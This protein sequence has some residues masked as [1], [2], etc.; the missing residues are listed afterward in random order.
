[1][2]DLLPKRWRR[3]VVAAVFSGMTLLV[4]G[5]ATAQGIGSHVGGG[6]LAGDAAGLDDGYV[7]FGGFV[8]LAQPTESVLFF[9]D[10]SLLLYNEDTDTLGGNAGVGA[11]FFSPEFNRIFGGY[12]YYDR[13]DLGP[14]EVDQIGFGIESLGRVWDTRLNVNLPTSSGPGLT[15]VNATFVGSGVLL[16]GVEHNALSVIEA[17]AGALLKE[18]DAT[19]LKAFVGVYG[20][21]DDSID[22]AAGV[23]GRIEARINDQLWVGAHVEHD[24][25]FDTTGG[26]TVEWRFGKGACACQSSRTNPLAR[27][28]DPV[29]RRRHVA[30]NRTEYNDTPLTIGG[31][32]VSVV[33]VD[34]NALT[35]VSLGFASPATAVAGTVENPYTTL[36]EASGSTA[37]VVYVYSGVYEGPQQ[38]ATISRDGQLWVAES[39][40][41]LVHGDQGAF[42]LSGNPN[43]VVIINNAGGDVFTVQADDVS[44]VGFEVNNA[45]G[46]VVYSATGA[47]NL[48]IAENTFNNSADAAIELG[49]ASSGS[50]EGN[51]ISGADNGVYVGGDY[52]GDIVDNEITGTV[53]GGALGVQI[54]GHMTGDFTDNSIT[55]VSSE[56]VS[57]TGSLTGDFARNTMHGNGIGGSGYDTAYIGGDVT[58]DIA[59]NSF[60]HTSSGQGRHGLYVG[61]D[62]YGDLKGN[63]ADFNDGGGLEIAGSV[64]GGNVVGNIGSNSSNGEGVRIGGTVT[65][66]VAGNTTSN[67]YRDGLYVGGEVKGSVTSNV[68]EDNGVSGL[69]VV[70]GVD[71]DLTDNDTSGNAGAGLIVGDYDPFDV[72]FDSTGTSL[73]P[74]SLSGFLASAA[75][76]ASASISVA[77]SDLTTSDDPGLP[78]GAPI[79]GDVANNTANDNGRDGILVGSVGGDLIGNRTDG[80]GQSGL[81][82]IGSVGGDVA[83]NQASDTG[84]YALLVTGD[85]G[86]DFRDNRLNNST[87]SLVVGDFS[88]GAGVHG[89]VAGSVTGNEFNNHYIGGWFQGFLDAGSE[90]PDTPAVLGDVTDNTVTGNWGIGMIIIGDVVGDVRNNDASDN[91]ID[92][93]ISHGLV[94]SGTVE[95]DVSENTASENGGD[96]IHIFGDVLGSVTGNTANNNADD[97]IDVDGAISGATSPNTTIGN[98]DQGF[99]N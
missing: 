81:A 54:A 5:V 72:G 67:N 35:T 14:W 75:P 11:R 15:G 28:G 43:A 3:R 73:V 2:L 66:D 49:G 7:H 62:L 59:D 50:I 24:E 47:T 17:E 61:G 18:W 57:I 77:E 42:T 91:V 44:I 29:V 63:T 13:R 64:V 69:V 74:T 97:G 32:A 88:Y 31:T 36:A 40:S 6:V 78:A 8:P 95:G 9:A 46:S 71:G 23:R 85:V 56:G 51:T 55:D 41:H 34:D 12:L 53:G 83:E 25:V 80:N 87:R 79:G 76:P 39:A 70:G 89:S 98:A 48:H 37:D 4:G 38:T 22:D 94:I 27:L 33:H 93:F 96:G 58:G 19:Q 26:V 21:F 60:T 30:I 10:G 90:D 16:N 86:G 1:M 20:L 45:A 92:D 84:N 52:T 65:G 82:V 99:E 68:A